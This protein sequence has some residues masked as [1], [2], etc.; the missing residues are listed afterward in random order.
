MA[1]TQKTAAPKKK[2]QG[3]QGVRHAI[4]IIICAFAVGVC[5]YLFFLGNPANF[6]NGDPEDI[7]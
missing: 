7:L 5:F 4:I 1:A 3:F 6:A 2:S